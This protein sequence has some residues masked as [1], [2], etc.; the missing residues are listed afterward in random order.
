MMSADDSAS[1]KFDKLTPTINA[2][3]SLLCAASVPI[4]A[5]TE[6]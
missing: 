5:I 1:G 2:M 6:E 4:L 3:V